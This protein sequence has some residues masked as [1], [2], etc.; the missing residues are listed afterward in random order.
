M[1][2]RKSG[3]KAVFSDFLATSC[4][5]A[6]PL[7]FGKCGNKRE[8]QGISGNKRT[9]GL[10]YSRIRS[11]QGRE[12]ERVPHAKPSRLC[13]NVGGRSLTDRIGLIW[14]DLPCRPSVRE[15]GAKG[16]AAKMRQK[17]PRP[18][19]WRTGK[20]NFRFQHFSFLLS[21]SRF[22]SSVFH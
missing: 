2:Q 1:V 18:G 19:C 11:T 22:L 7:G 21:P 8:Y 4:Q 15:N 5:D 20:I 9:L 16:M 14:F 6:G 17:H 10:P 12:S 3:Q 13:R